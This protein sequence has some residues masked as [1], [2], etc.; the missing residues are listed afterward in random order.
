V[1][2]RFGEK[3]NLYRCDEEACDAIRGRLRNALALLDMIEK[4]C[5]REVEAIL[6]G[7]L[8]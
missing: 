5:G 1:E 4:I 2:D 3:L 6:A 7:V 8:P